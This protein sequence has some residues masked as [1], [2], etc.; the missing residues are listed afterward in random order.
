MRYFITF[1][2]DG[3]NFC[4]YQRQPRERTVQK[5]M[6]D[7]L[8][9]IS[10]GDSVSVC[11]SGRTDA[12]VHAINQKATFDLKRRLVLRNCTE[13]LILCYRMMC[14]LRRYKW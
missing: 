11:A 2:Y 7:A 14:M 6:E 9:E 13:H 3:S 5:V 12:L 10:G 4:G 8:K 1:S